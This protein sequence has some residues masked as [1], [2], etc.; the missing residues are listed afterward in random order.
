ILIFS[1]NQD[2]HMDHLRQV[3]DRIRKANLRLNKEKCEF[4]KDEI[5]FLGFRIKDGT[6]RPSD[7][8]TEIL[9]N[10]PVPSS[11]RLLKG[12]LGL[13]NFF[14]NLIPDFAELAQ[15]LFDASNNK[16]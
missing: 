6:K 15:P 14:R 2:V 9:A 16:K 5:E 13:A 12:F 3:L 8:K 1:D 10:F 11:P 4:G 7:E